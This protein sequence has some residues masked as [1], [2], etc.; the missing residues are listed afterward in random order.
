MSIGRG[1]QSAV[2]YYLACTPCSN[3]RV[4]RKRKKEAQR[5]REDRELLEAQMP[6]MYRHPSPQST[7]PHWHGEI[8]LGPGPTT[9]GGKRKATP[10]SESQR[11]NGMLKTSATQSS[12]GSN[13]ASSTDVGRAYGADDR[14]DSKYSFAQHQRPDEEL[15]RFST[16]EPP[17]RSFLDGSTIGSGVQKPTR[18]YMRDHIGYH[19]TRNPMINDLHP[20]TVTKVQSRDDIAWMMQPPPTADV[21]SGKS[22]PTTSRSNTGVSRLSA[23]STPMS[24]QASDQSRHYTRV[25]EDSRITNSLED[26][27]SGTPRQ[28][29][30]QRHDRNSGALTVE[31]RDFATSPSKRAKRRPSPIITGHPSEDSEDTI[32]HRPSLVPDALRD[33]KPRRLASRPQLSTILSDSVMPSEDDANFFTPAQTPKENSLPDGH[34]SEAS[35]ME[36]DKTSRRP[37]LLVKDSSLRVLQE[38]TPK[39]PMFKTGIFATSPALEAMI[40]LPPAEGEEER[41]LTGGPELFESIYHPGFELGEWVHRH[42]RR[43]GIQHRWSMDI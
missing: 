23:T 43:E 10:N 27:R 34:S 1:F 21:M 39:A 9:R 28:P 31:A 40:S 33:V 4:R 18:A 29:A 32:I 25:S 35:S 36:R 3:T 38:R 24:R 14:H 16:A 6:N 20:A 13:V 41:R 37:A 8:T 22:R 17:L 15:W 30:E 42:T 12:N 7:N 2:F 19:A 5:D 11:G 26:G